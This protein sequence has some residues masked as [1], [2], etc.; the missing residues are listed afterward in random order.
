MGSGSRVIRISGPL[1]PSLR[2][3]EP[4][5]LIVEGPN[6]QRVLAV[7]AQLAGVQSL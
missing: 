5:I 4:T 1:G 2:L 7:L 3:E 6:D